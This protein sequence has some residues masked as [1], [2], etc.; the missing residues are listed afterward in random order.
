MTVGFRFTSADLELLPDIEGV[1]YEIIDGDLYVSSAPGEPHQYA[2]TVLASAIHQWSTQTGAGLTTVGP[3]LVFS[4]DNDVIPDVVWISHARRALARD[5]KDH[6]RIAPELV[7][8][9]LS[10][11]IVNERRDRELKL[12]LYSRQGVQDYWIVDCQQHT[13]EI[14]RRA[15][16]ELQLAAIL[17][18]AEAITSPLL[19]P[20][21]SCPVA[22]L[23]APEI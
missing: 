22:D 13:V 3:G 17:S 9:V 14:Y 4:E 18:D 11:G 1:H 20:G 23:W 10:P 15:D 8:E 7:V 12:Q 2:C 21:F 5:E 6:Y 16:A 19:L